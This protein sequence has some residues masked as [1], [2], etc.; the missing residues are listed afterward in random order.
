MTREVGHKVICPTEDQ[1]QIKLV[2]WLIMNRIR[3]YA[4]PNGGKRGFLE[5]AKLK[6]CG[7]SPGVPDICIPVPTKTHHGLYLEL[8]RVKG[9]KTSIYQAEWLNYL[10]EVGYYAE[11]A[12][13]FDEA[14]ELVTHYLGKVPHRT[15]C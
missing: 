15:I 14:K 3:F 2:T 11:V 7:V 4:I 13:G 1:E 8:K 12:K 10:R 5:A 6:R 9:G